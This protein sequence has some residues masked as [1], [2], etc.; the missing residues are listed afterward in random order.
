MITTALSAATLE[1]AYDAINAASAHDQSH[2][3]SHAAL[4]SALNPAQSTLLIMDETAPDRAIAFGWYEVTLDILRYEGW[5][6]PTAR[7]QGYG[8]ALLDWIEQKAHDLGIHKIKSG[9][10]YS[11]NP[12]ALTI[13]AAHGYVEVRRFDQRWADLTTATFDSTL[14]PPDGL[15][16]EHYSEAWMTALVEAQRDSFSTHWDSQSRVESMTARA[17]QRRIEDSARF[18]PHNFWLVCEGDQVA[19]FALAEPSPLNGRPDD[20]WIWQVGTRHAYQR[21]GLARLL[22]SRALARLQ[23]DHYQ[24]AGLHVDSENPAAIALYESLGLRLTRQRVHF[25]KT[26]A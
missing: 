12:D 24:R 10:Y 4:R 8:A 26:L 5:V 2:R 25:V 9:Q 3:I 19:A 15:R 17:I 6:R 23:S 14:T 1:A 18:D 11:D 22:L 16:I 13:L 20:S 21:R 7:G